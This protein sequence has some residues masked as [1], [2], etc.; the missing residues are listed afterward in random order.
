MANVWEIIIMTWT[1]ASATRE[2]LFL[3]LLS[4]QWF[5]TNSLIWK[6]SHFRV[7]TSNTALSSHRSKPFFTASNSFGLGQNVLVMGQN[8]VVFGKSK[9]FLMV[10]KEIWSS[11]FKVMLDLYSDYDFEKE[12]THNIFINKGSSNLFLCSIIDLNMDLIFF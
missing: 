12:V 10:A 9:L 7:K 2:S 4:A 6:F 1:T 11:W 3:L 8:Q 5:K